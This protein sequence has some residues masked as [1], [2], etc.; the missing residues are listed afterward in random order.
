MINIIYSSDKIFN[1]N[2]LQ[3]LFLSVQWESG[4]YPDEL[5]KAINNYSTVYSAWHEEKL[6]GL[7]CVM[8]DGYL[9]AYIQYLLVDPQYQRIG[10][11]T[12]LIRLILIKYSKF[13]NISL[14]SYKENV[15]FYKNCGFEKDDDAVAMF[16]NH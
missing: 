3:Q 8:D 9:N 12:S 4:N 7:I 14:L 2:Q 15:G 1:P 11:G 5:P 10:I 16:F 6:V 13:K